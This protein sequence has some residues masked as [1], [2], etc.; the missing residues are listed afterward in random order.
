MD[1]VDISLE[2]I[3]NNGIAKNNAGEERAIATNTTEINKDM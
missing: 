2:S 1:N 3:N